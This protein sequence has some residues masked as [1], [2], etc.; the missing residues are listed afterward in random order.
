MGADKSHLKC[1]C[2]VQGE[3]VRGSAWQPG[4]LGERPAS[5]RLS[6]ILRGDL[7]DQVS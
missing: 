1:C 5:V 3:Q 7:P 4:V 2:R 6:L